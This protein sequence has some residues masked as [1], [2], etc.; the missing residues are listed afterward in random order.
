ME[1]ANGTNI[2][3]SHLACTW[4]TRMRGEGSIKGG[5]GN[6]RRGSRNK[7]KITI[8][9]R[10]DFVIKSEKNIQEQISL[11]CAENDFLHYKPVHLHILVI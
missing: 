1:S 5:R 11:D 9:S 3:T 2:N 8:T 4:T 10:T 7:E 6:R